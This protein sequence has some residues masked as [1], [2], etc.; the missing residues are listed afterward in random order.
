MLLGNKSDCNKI[1]LNDAFVG[2]IISDVAGLWE[3]T[4]S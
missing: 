1:L 2:D 4:T 3:T